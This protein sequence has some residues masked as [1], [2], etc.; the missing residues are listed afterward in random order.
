MPFVK[1]KPDGTFVSSVGWRARYGPG[2]PDLSRAKV[3]KRRCDASNSAGEGEVVE[4][5][6][7]LVEEPPTCS[8]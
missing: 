7:E 5:R 6:L 1:R 4:V 3:F 2:A 8:S